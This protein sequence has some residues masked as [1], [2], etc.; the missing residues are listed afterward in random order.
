M[1]STPWGQAALVDEIVLPQHVAGVALSPRMSSCSRR[2]R[3]SGS[4]G[5]RTR[6]APRLRCGEGRS[7]SA[8]RSRAAARGAGGASGA[9]LRVRPRRRQAA[10]AARRAR[11]ASTSEPRM[12]QPS[13]EPSSGSTACSG[14]GISPITLP[15]QFVTPAT[16]AREPFGFASVLVAEDDLPDGLELRRVGIGPAAL[17]VLDRDHEPLRRART[18]TSSACRRS[19]RGAARR[20]RRTRATRSGG[21]R[22][23]GVPPRTGSGSRCRSRAPARRRRRTALTASITGANRA[24]APQRR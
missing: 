9:R 23:A 14:C 11:A 7:R 17:A 8:R 10:A 12:R 21:A 5:S 16:S 19:R 15:S 6:P 20:G 3:A 2:R 1:A 13:V 24:I 22:R 4:S 18:G